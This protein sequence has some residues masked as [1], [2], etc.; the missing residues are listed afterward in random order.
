MSRNDK[1]LTGSTAPGAVDAFLKEV[2]E[3][4]MPR[5]ESRVGRLIFALDATASREP[6]W[7]TACH[8][9]SEMFEVTRSLGGL[10]VQLCFY[11]GFGECKTSAWCSRPAVLRDCMGAVSCRGGLTQIRKV[12][13]HAIKETGRGKVDALIFVGDCMEEKPDVLCDL[14]GQLGVLGVPIF[15]FQE[16]LDAEAGRVFRQ[17]A[18]LS[19]GAY[20]PFDSGSPSQLRDLLTAVAVYVAGGVGAL[21]DFGRGRGALVPHLLSQ[22][23][24][25]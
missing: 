20:A 14:A 22:L 7:D 21:E 24:K 19:G 3:T 15:I 5:P 4:P 18:R 6:T 8:I 17:L 11:R 1:T 13:N 25:G 2:A 16:G 23:N 12:L 10:Q 9:Q